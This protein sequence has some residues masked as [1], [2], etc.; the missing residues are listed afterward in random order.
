[1]ISA[2]PHW[3]ISLSRI[4]HKWGF[5][6]SFVK[7][8]WGCPAQRNVP[9][10]APQDESITVDALWLKRLS[11]AHYCILEQ[12]HK[13]GKYDTWPHRVSNSQNIHKTSD[14]E[15]NV[16]IHLISLSQSPEVGTTAPTSQMSWWRSSCVPVTRSWREASAQP[17]PSDFGSAT[18]APC[19]EPHISALILGPKNFLN[20]LF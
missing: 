20:V 19:C 6:R 2:V 1:M 16:H 3:E 5:S 12:L 8:P 10:P 9:T 15:K 13:S 7:T 4:F 18:P 17:R 14:C 11:S